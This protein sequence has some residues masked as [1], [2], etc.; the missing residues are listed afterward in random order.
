MEKVFSCC[1]CRIQRPGFHEAS[2]K[3]RDLGIKRRG[4]VSCGLP[5]ASIVGC[6]PPQPVNKRLK[7]Q[8]KSHPKGWLFL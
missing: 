6:L 2:P 3:H 7:R 5:I 4:G 8:K 1:L